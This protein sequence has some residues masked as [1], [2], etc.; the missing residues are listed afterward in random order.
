MIV[1]KEWDT[2][3][4][5]HVPYEWENDKAGTKIGK[6]GEDA[7]LGKDAG[8]DLLSLSMSRRYK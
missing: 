4:D 8:S 5:S 7:K 2:H 6:R 1:E 3:D